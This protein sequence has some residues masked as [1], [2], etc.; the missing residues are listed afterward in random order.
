M[1]EYLDSVNDDD[2][3]L[4]SLPF[5]EIYEKKLTHRIV[6][7]L[8]FNDKGEMALQIRSQNKSFCPGCYCTSAGGHVS[9]GESYEEAAI[10]EMNEELGIN[11]E[12]V[13]LGKTVY[14]DPRNIKKFLSVYTAE[15]SGNFKTNDEVAGMEFMDLEKIR[16]LLQYSP[17]VHPE[18]RLILETYYLA[19]NNP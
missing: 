2:E 19:N 9:S 18:L 5:N 12:I 13:L 17:K 15:H 4:S 1:T 14:N 10:R 16:S 11:P 8:V 6:H 7:V 3:I